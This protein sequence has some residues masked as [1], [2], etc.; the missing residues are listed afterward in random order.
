MTTIEYLN[1]PPKYNTYDSSEED[2]YSDSDYYYDENNRRRT[3]YHWIA[4]R[5][6]TKKIRRIWIMVISKFIPQYKYRRLG[7]STKQTCPCGKTKK[8]HSSLPQ[9]NNMDMEE[10]LATRTIRPTSDL[11][12]DI[13]YNDD[14]G[15]D[16]SLLEDN[17]EN[18]D[19]SVLLMEMNNNKK[20]IPS[21]AAKLLDI[22]Q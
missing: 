1:L 15:L 10:F 12:K 6:V 11:D 8:K 17:D 16:V 4:Y 7:S 19:N 21:K 22:Q 18:L 3:R 5:L 14:M 20:R 13:N 9:H 2:E